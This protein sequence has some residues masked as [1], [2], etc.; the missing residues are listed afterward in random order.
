MVQAAARAGLDFSAAATRDRYWWMK[1]RWILDQLEN[2]HSIDLYKLQHAQH[3]AVL[4]YSLPS[5]QTFDTHWNGANKSLTQIFALKFPWLGDADTKGRDSAIDGML[6]QWRAKYG[7]MKDP[8]V[9]KKYTDLA[10]RWRGQTGK[11]KANQFKDHKKMA[12]MLDKLNEKH[13]RKRRK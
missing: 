9:R 8:A 3:V 7:D 1:A 2:E 12:V 6:A 11:A 4:D 10:K 5:Q 13:K